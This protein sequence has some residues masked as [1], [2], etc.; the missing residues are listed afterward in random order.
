MNRAQKDATLLTAMKNRLAQLE[1]A[2]R[3]EVCS[4]IR[5]EF[6][7]KALGF[8]EAITYVEGYFNLVNT[9]EN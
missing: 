9:D 5:L 1:D 4:S 2:S 8:K 7:D 6:R 3:N